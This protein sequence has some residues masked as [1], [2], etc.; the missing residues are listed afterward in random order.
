MS[1]TK[2]KQGTIPWYAPEY[3][4]SG[5]KRP[6]VDYLTL[7]PQEIKRELEKHVVGQ[8]EACRQ[9]AIMM[10]QHLQGHRFVGMLAGPTGSGK[11]YM[12]EVLKRLF[13][14][15]VHLREI[16]NITNDGWSGGKKVSSLFKNVNN[17]YYYKGKIFPL[18]V[19]EE[20]DK[21]IAP[22]IS[23]G[24][25][26]VSESLQAEFLSA[27]HGGY[28]EYKAEDG[29]VLTV[30]TGSM[31]F[32]FAGAF[33]KRAR[34]VAEKASQ[35][36]FGFGAVDQK[37]QSYSQSLTMEDIRE[38][39][40]ISELCGRIQKLICLNKMEEGHF[41]QMLDIREKGP[42]FELEN[43]FNIRF[44]LSEEKKFEMAHLAYESGLG[45]RGIKN[46]LRNYIDEAIWEDC[47]TRC[48]EIA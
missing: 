3:K 12:T 38:A 44:H 8:E 15:V 46:Q 24:G 22:K 14:D 48:V 16:S 26:N 33:E 35:S 41:K 39:G 1:S 23:S 34:A 45:I 28:V 19:L 32:L 18:I 31:S 6:L 40:C 11:S 47:N 7:T 2:E 9:V 27:I 29:R 5:S 37:V 13:P 42:I 4:D 43:E 25:E 17:P 20:C 10:Y 36:S 30:D 21:M